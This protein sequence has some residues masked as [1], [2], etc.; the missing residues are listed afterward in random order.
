MNKSR[1][2][3]GH[4]RHRHHQ[5]AGDHHRLGQGDR[6]AHLPRHRLAVPPHQRIL[7]RAES[8][9]PDGEIP[10]EDRPHHRRLFFGHQ[11]QVDTGSYP[12]RPRKAERGE[13]LFGTVETWLIWKLT[14]GKLHVTDYTNASR[15]MMF[16]IHTLEWDDEILQELNIPKCMLPKPVPSSGF[17][18]YADPM[19][20]GGEIKLPVRQ[21][22]N[23]RPSSARPA[24]P[25][26][27][28][29]T[30]SAPAAFCS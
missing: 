2:G 17:Y 22:T 30:P 20:F 24:L 14:C 19:H 26:A 3:R 28:R 23:R 5:P 12:R 21:A 4:R 8:P 10:A 11:A 1:P 6:G 15:T 25:R 9:G 18:E 16:N 27:R 7:R 13:L 29:K